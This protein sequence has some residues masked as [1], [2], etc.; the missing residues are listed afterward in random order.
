MQKNQSISIPELPDRPKRILIAEDELLVAQNLQSDLQSL[1]YE[2]IGPAP[3]GEKAL[4][5]LEAHDPDLLLLDISMPKLNGVEVAQAVNE[6]RQKPIIVISAYS[7]SEYI[8]GCTEAGIYG[9]LLKPVSI[10]DLRVTISVSWSKYLEQMQLHGEVV[11]LNQ[12]LEDRK[13]I[14]RAKGILMQNLGIT[15]PEAMKRLQK[16]ARDSRRPM[17]HLAKSVIEAHE[18]MDQPAQKSG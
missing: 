17:A 15:E 13:L 3:N 2:V 1:G 12:K 6:K 10:D 8:K 9:Y 7:D 16:Q 5:L 14:E 11:T 18:L 4:E